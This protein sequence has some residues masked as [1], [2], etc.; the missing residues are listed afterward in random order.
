MTQLGGSVPDVVMEICG[1]VTE[2]LNR[3]GYG[4]IDADCI[5]TGRDFLIKIWELLLSV[6]VGVAVIHGGMSPQTMA[7][8]FYEL[9]FMQAYGKETIMIRADDVGVPSDLI[10]TEHITYDGSLRDRVASFMEA[11]AERAN[12]YA[13]VADQLERNPL[14]SIDYL[15]RAYLLSGDKGC[16][17]RVSHIIEHAGIEN[18]ARTSV[19]LLLAAF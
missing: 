12:H 6:P 11:V 4:L 5:T 1:Q 3:H 7:N 8:V 13:Y 19:E 2:V 16:R 10:R 9:G 14:L 17:A 18:R 15:R